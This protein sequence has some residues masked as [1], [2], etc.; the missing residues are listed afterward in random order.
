M[1][2]PTAPA[3]PHDGLPSSLD[4]APPAADPRPDASRSGARRA[5]LGP[6]VAIVA[7]AVAIGVAVVG[8]SVGIAGLGGQAGS[9]SILGSLPSPSP[10]A[11]VSPEPGSWAG[12]HPPAG[13]RAL[14]VVAGDSPATTT[15]V[16]AIEGWADEHGV[17]LQV[18]REVDQVGVE[19]RI[20]SSAG[21]DLDLVIGAGAEVVDGF[22]Y[23]TPQFF[24]RQFLIVGAQVAEPTAN[25]TAVIWDGA[26]FRGTG[27]AAA[28]DQDAASVTPARSRD[29][30][31]LGVAAVLQGLTG[32]VLDLPS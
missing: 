2:A 18:A 22:T 13:Y 16:A 28:G 24:D 19:Q 17:A 7:S 20:V 31:E 11:T 4:D 12:V 5:A 10:E 27:L 15:L 30:V 21:A 32:I 23:A 3:P 9:R 25:M 8:V 1:D 26:T 6:L 14:L 29:A